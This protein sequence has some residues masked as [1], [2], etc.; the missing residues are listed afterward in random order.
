MIPF[1]SVSQERRTQ[2]QAYINNIVTEIEAAVAETDKEAMACLF[3]EDLEKLSNELAEVGHDPKTEDDD[4]DYS[5]ELLE[6]IEDTDGNSDQ[7]SN[8]SSSPAPNSTDAGMGM[9]FY[10]T[11]SL[12]FHDASLRPFPVPTPV[13]EAPWTY[14]RIHLIGLAAG[15]AHT[16]AYC[17]A[18]EV[19]DAGVALAPSRRA[20]SSLQ[21]E[22]CHHPGCKAAMPTCL[23]EF[24]LKLCDQKP[25]DPPT[26]PLEAVPNSTVEQPVVVA[27]EELDEISPTPLEVETLKH[28]GGPENQPNSPS[29]LGPVTASDEVEPIPPIKTKTVK[30]RV[31]GGF[32]WVT[33]PEA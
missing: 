24:H 26:A 28:T 31:G 6:W 17:E 12:V 9:N 14:R 15:G 13:T 33:I 8:E 30:K 10:Q 11:L 22:Q 19:V 7:G 29:V 23:M 20:F 5:D 3:Q 4:A 1:G 18:N 21:Y 2:V 16:F 32:V 25:V 27:D